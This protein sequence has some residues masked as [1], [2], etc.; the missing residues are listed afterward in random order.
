LDEVVGT[1]AELGMAAVEE[2]LDLLVVVVKG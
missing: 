2:M 1:V